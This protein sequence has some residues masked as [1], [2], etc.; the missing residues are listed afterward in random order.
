VIIGLPCRWLAQ[1]SSTNDVA[2]EWALAGAP[3]GAMVVAARQ[4]RGRGRRERS[5][6]SPAGSGLYASFVWRPSWPAQQAPRLGILAGMAAYGAL[7]AAGVPELRVK[8]P[9][10]VL[11]AGNKIGGVLV[12][13]RIGGEQIEFAVA[14]IGIN[15]CQQRADFSPAVRERATSCALAGVSVSV[16]HMLEQL[17]GSWRAVWAMPFEQVRLNWLAAGARDEEPE[18]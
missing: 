11:S 16:D 8:W 12:E 6:D 17:I 1:T 3:A 18:L 4:V 7:E 15:I 5:W 2:R 14:G 9:N 13:P 10:D